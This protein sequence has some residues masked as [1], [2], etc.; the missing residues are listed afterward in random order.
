MTKDKQIA[1][2]KTQ[3]KDVADSA[4]DYR[5]Q[6]NAADKKADHLQAEV[7]EC[8][9]M[10]DRLNKTITKERKK[11]S[12]LKEVA[13]FYRAQR[14]RVDAYLSAT[15]D[16]DQRQEI[17]TYGPKATYDVERTTDAEYMKP[18][19]PEDRR[20]PITEPLVSYSQ[21]GGGREFAAYRDSEPNIDWEAF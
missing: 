11:I 17:R 13:R 8:S 12:N 2:L 15:L 19:G 18:K 16:A 21:P 5:K 6:W 1:K 10:N 3:L 7:D 4:N 14:D 9:G 20:P